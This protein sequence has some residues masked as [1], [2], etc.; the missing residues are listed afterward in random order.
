MAS[1]GFEWDYYYPDD[2]IRF[3]FEDMEN[4]GYKAY[5]VSLKLRTFR[6]KNTFRFI[7]D[8]PGCVLADIREGLGFSKDC[9]MPII[10]GFAE[11]E[12]ILYTE[13]YPRHYSVNQEMID[14][15]LDNYKQRVFKMFPDVKE[16]C[17]KREMLKKAKDELREINKE[18]A[19]E[20]KQKQQ[21]EQAGKDKKSEEDKS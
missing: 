12:I 17:E 1:T 13:G 10:R 18:I 7:Y 15:I 19:E 16:R 21:E 4:F 5:W 9:L 20:N 6:Q 8:H 2:G 14:A 11:R 3:S